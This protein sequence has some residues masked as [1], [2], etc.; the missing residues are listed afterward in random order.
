MIAIHAMT[1]VPSFVTTA[2]VS[3][4]I[5]SVVGEMLKR[6]DAALAFAVTGAREWLSGVGMAAVVRI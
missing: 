4:A 5:H 6:M 2:P 1:A 3:I